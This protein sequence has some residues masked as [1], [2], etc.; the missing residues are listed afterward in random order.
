MALMTTL[1]R[2]FSLSTPADG[3]KPRAKRLSGGDI[4]PFF[5][6]CQPNPA[7]QFSNLFILCKIKSL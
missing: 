7:S 1:P 2:T 5:D 3:A 6:A 4:A